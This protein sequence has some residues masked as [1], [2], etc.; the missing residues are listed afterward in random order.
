M[1]K[2]QAFIDYQDQIAKEIMNEIYPEEK[3]VQNGGEIK[4]LDT[5]TTAANTPEPEPEKPSYCAYRTGNGS[6]SE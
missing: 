3:G 6:E 5:E 4:R 2:K 1:N